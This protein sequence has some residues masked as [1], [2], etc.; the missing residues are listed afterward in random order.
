VK[1]ETLSHLSPETIEAVR[2]SLAGK[3]LVEAGSGWDVERSLVGAEY[4]S[5]QVTLRVGT[6]E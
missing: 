6:R 2:A 3:N 5:D 4:L 1:N